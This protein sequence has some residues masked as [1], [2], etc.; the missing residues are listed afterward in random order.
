MVADVNT[1]KVL[2]EFSRGSKL[3]N[4]RCTEGG[5]WVTLLTMQRGMAG[6][7]ATWPFSNAP[8]WVH[9]RNMNPGGNPHPVSDI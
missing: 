5:E 1:E 7:E 3:V 9:Q 2:V 8:W 4:S 6:E